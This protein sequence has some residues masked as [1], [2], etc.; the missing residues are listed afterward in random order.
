MKKKFSVKSLKEYHA[1]EYAALGLGNINILENGASGQIKELYLTFL[2][3]KENTKFKIIYEGKNTSTGRSCWLGPTEIEV[4]KEL[5]EALIK[6]KYGE[7]V[8]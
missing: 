3:L 4:T 5:Y 1:N 2:S 6:S 8:F 7:D